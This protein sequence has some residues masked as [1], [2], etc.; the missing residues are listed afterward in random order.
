MEL[1]VRT[2]V[3][4]VALSDGGWYGPGWAGAYRDGLSKRQSAV[5]V[6]GSGQPRLDLRLVRH[7]SASVR[8]TSD[9]ER[10]AVAFGGF[11]VVSG[12]GRPG[13]PRVARG[14][15]PAP[16]P[17]AP[18]GINPVSCRAW[19]TP[20]PVSQCEC[21]RRSTV[22]R[23]TRAAPPG[24][25]PI[26]PTGT[27]S[28]GCSSGRCSMTRPAIRPLLPP[29]RGR[30]RR[31]GPRPLGRPGGAAVGGAFHP[32]A[33][34][35]IAELVPGRSEPLPVAFCLGVT[36]R[37]IDR[38]SASSRPCWPGGPARTWRPG[39]PGRRRRCTRPGTGCA[40]SL[41]MGFRCAT[42]RNC[43]DRPQTTRRLGRLTGLGDRSAAVYL[44]GA[45]ADC[46]LTA[47]HVLLLDR[48]GIHPGYRPLVTAFNLLELTASEL[49]DPC[50]PQP[51]WA[52][53][54]A[55]A[56]SARL[57]PAAPLG[58]KGI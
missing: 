43:S 10:I 9:A 1:S 57:K 19:L 44:D 51:P 47:D 34:R 3:S 7:S 18:V 48:L 26:W 17:R 38:D 22:R 15:A 23:P 11:H 8:T 36:T 25:S 42:C 5:I 54:R 27:P 55:P 13:R 20:Y 28:T 32:E 56:R 33:I 16:G 52:A 6:T 35:D 50:Y 39:W 40:E 12:G 21:R 58:R 29:A 53:S 30:A 14:R 2:F 49:P 31:R 37:D 46:E 24:A 45:Q 4:V 41:A